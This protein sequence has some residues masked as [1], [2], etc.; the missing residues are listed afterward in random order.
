MDPVASSEPDYA[1]ALEGVPKL[2]G[3]PL[4]AG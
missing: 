3:T 1:T 2:S 4:R